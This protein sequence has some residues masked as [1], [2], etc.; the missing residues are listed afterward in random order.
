MCS[1]R[2]SN[3]WFSFLLSKGILLRGEKQCTCFSFY[4]TKPK[5]ILDLDPYKEICSTQSKSKRLSLFLFQLWIWPAFIK[6]KDRQH[7]LNSKTKRSFLLHYQAERTEHLQ[8]SEISLQRNDVL[9]WS[10]FVS[11]NHSYNPLML[12]LS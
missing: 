1:G 2:N 6:R 4:L 9:T 8:T 12:G 7:S 3:M 5:T 11:E 10:D